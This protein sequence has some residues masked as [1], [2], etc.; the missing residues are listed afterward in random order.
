[1][2]NPA[3][4]PTRASKRLRSVGDQAPARVTQRLEASSLIAL[5]VLTLLLGACS[6]QADDAAGS[7]S[8]SAAST[9]VASASDNEAVGGMPAKL[10]K[11]L[12]ELAPH[13]AQLSAFGIQ[14]QLVMSIASAFDA[15]ATA[16]RQV[17]SDIDTVAA[18]SCPAARDTLLKALKLNSLQEAVR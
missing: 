18:A 10:C 13:A 16:L 17:S 9:P 3:T 7:G 2:S 12:N 15:N 11:V 14:A 4:P 1:M 8:K 6:K 5:C